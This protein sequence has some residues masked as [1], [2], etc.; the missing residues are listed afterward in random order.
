[1]WFE[2]WCQGTHSGFEENAAYIAQLRGGYIKG[3]RMKHISLKL[4][5]TH[6]L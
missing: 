5:F 1:M 2:V 3:D 4:F 6:D